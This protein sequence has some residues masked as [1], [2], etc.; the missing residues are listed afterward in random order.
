M[1]SIL[2][3]NIK[4]LRMEQGYSQGKFADICGV[5]KG[6]ISKIEN[7]VLT[8]LSGSNIEKIAAGLHVKIDDLVRSEDYIEYSFGTIEDAINFVLDGDDLLL[9]GK[10]MTEAQA[11]FLRNGLESLLETAKLIK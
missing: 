1:V 6:T 7:G 4:K 9:G 10:P 2:G 3:Q 5:S 8:S 11:K